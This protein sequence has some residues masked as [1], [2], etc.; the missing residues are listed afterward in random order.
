MSNSYDPWQHAVQL[1]FARV[2]QFLFLSV[3]LGLAGWAALLHWVFESSWIDVARYTW[4]IL[5]TTT[6]LHWRVHLHLCALVG[7]Q[8]SAWLFTTVILL[9]RLQ[10][11]DR[12]HRGPVVVKHVQG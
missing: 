3:F 7:A 2:L 11:G 5:S 10:S 9:S 12:H 6:N 1:F 4:T 8:L